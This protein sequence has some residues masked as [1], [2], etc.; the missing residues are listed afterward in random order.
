MKRFKLFPIIFLFLFPLAAQQYQIND[1]EYQIQGCGHWIFGRTQEYALVTQVPVDQ[2]TVFENEEDFTAYITDLEIKL[3]NLR[4]FETTSITYEPILQ[5]EQSEI[6]PVKL[7]ISVKDSFHLFAI[8][9]PKYNSNTGLTFKLKIKD[10][11][12]LGSLNTLSSDIYF[13]IPTSESDGTNTEFGFN[14]GAD[15]PFKAGIFDAIWLNDLSLSY[16]IGDS[17]PEWNVGTGLRL[18]LP[19]EK[20]S[21]IF[22][23]NQ[24][25]INNFEYLDFEDNLYFVNDFKLYLPLTIANL[26][27][28]GNL[29]YTP[30]SILSINWDRDGISKENSALSSPITTIGH[31][32]AFGRTDWNQ[33]LRTGFSLSLDNF[34]TYNFQRKRLYPQLELIMYGY[35]KIDLLEDS[36]FLRNLGIVTKANIFT[37]LFNPKKDEY[38]YNDGNSIGQHLRGIRDSQVYAGTNIS[39]L[40]PTNALILNFDLP[41]HLF[42]TNFTKS[43]LRYFNF[44]FQVSPFFDMALCYNK[45]TQTYFSFE[46]GFY[47]AGLEIIV[48]PAKWS[49]ITLRGSIG[50]DAGRKFFANHINMDWREDVSKKEFSIGFGLHY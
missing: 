22:E 32:I 14:C 26:N 2:K 23:T 4:A 5:E 19:M 31:K 41:I 21:L 43:F 12:F 34:Y 33:N 10:S 42:T 27:Y 28:F 24:K 48:Y 46:D 50:I 44:D 45:I 20:T 11:N 39:A 8:P 38:I 17:M 36:Y 1:I 18:T 29:T 25:F 16:T 7:I 49:G 13:L 35:K 30:Y 9:G 40:N 15:Y 3:N 47:G 6:I 37:F